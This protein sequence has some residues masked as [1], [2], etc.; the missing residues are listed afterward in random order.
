MEWVSRLSI[1]FLAYIFIPFFCEVGVVIHDKTKVDWG[2]LLVFPNVTDVHWGLLISTIVWANGGYDSMG[3][4]AGEVKEGSSTFVLGL[5]GAFPIV[6]INY[7]GPIILSYL[8]F[9]YWKKWDANWFLWITYHTFKLPGD[10]LGKF[11]ASATVVSNFAQFNA[12]LAPTARAVWAMAIGREGGLGEHRYLPF[13]LSWSYTRASGEI[14]PVMA[15]LFCSSTA[16]LIS[17]LPLNFVIQLYLVIRLVN[18]WSEYAALIYLRFKE[19]DRARPYEVPLGKVGSILLFLPT[20]TIS[21]LVLTTADTH[22]LITGAA[23]TIVILLSFCVKKFWL[24]WKRRISIQAQ[25]G[26]TYY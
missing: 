6:L 15:I 12:G 3:S 24:D 25:I 1:F 19:P 4:L 26:P 14:L 2:D 17:A 18:L 11:M 9:P 21:M 20:L 16:L 8:I 23:A 10:W 22:V 5:L 13:F 7:V